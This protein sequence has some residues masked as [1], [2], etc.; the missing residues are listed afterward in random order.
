MHSK[1]KSHK[2]SRFEAEETIEYDRKATI[3]EIQVHELKLEFVL[4]LDV[5]SP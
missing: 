1:S 4:R 2:I 5:W 3:H